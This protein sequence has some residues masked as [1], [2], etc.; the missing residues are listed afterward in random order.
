ML[1]TIFFLLLVANK[2]INFSADVFI[3]AL[4]ID[5]FYFFLYFVIKN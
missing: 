3:I 4:F 5:L 2:S 1:T